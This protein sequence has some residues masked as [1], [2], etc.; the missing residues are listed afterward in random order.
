LFAAANEQKELREIEGAGHVDLQV[1][2]GADYNR[3][4]LAFL[5]GVLG[6]EVRN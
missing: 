6:S 5:K 1:F 3:R 4:I 2:A